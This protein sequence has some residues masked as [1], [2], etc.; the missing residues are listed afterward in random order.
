MA[1]HIKNRQRSKSLNLRRVENDLAKALLMLGQEQAE[2]SV[3]FVGSAKMKQLNQDYRGIPKETDVLSF[4]MEDTSF[5]PHTSRLALHLLGDIVISVPK[6]VAQAQAYN[7]HF[8]EELLRLLIHGL[9]HLVG[10][11]HEKSRYQKENM[12]KKEREILHA[13]SRLA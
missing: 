10:Y 3:I 7:V 8:Y 1:I 11:D 5:R 9:L 4:P 13:V 12:M 6:T 2:L